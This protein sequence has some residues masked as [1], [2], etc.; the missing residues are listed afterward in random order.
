MKKKLFE[1]F[2]LPQKSKSDSNSLLIN[3]G[4]SPNFFNE[5]EQNALFLEKEI[6]KK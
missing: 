2:S 6:L 4:F 3:C 5:L 1:G